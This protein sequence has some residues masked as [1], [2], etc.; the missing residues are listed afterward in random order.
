MPT[1]TR[2][3]NVYLTSSRGIVHGHIFPQDEDYQGLHSSRFHLTN[4]EF[5]G[6]VLCFPLSPIP[7]K[8]S[9][10]QH[11][12][13]DDCCSVDE[14]KPLT[15]RLTL[16]SVLP[17]SQSKE[18]NSSTCLLWWCRLKNVLASPRWRT[19]PGAIACQQILPVTTGLKIVVLP[20]VGK[21]WWKQFLGCQ[22]YACCYLSPRCRNLCRYGGG[23][24][25]CVSRPS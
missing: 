20:K 24:G 15:P 4:T 18:W 19:L 2:C 9:L 10:D 21:E 14:D 25:K 8:W 13:V 6:K 1:W 11:D 22:C 3:T 5:Y 16:R 17:E 7:S 12:G 23:W